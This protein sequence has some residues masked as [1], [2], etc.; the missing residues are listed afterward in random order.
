LGNGDPVYNQTSPVAVADLTGARL[1][2]TAV[3][4]AAGSGATCA[5]L[6]SG[7]SECWGD[8]EQGQLGNSSFADQSTPAGVSGLTGGTPASAVSLGHVVATQPALPGVPSAVAGQS[9][10]TTTIELSWSA[11]EN[12]GGAD[13]TDYALEYRVVGAPGELEWV[14]VSHQHGATTTTLIEGLTSGAT[15]AFRVAAITAAGQG[16]WSEESASVRTLRV[17]GTPGTP[18]IVSRTSTSITIRWSEASA[19][20]SAPVLYDVQYRAGSGS[21]SM[22]ERADSSARTATAT[23][24]RAGSSY[25]FRVRAVTQ[26]GWGAWSAVSAAAVAAGK[27]GLPGAVT[28]SPTR[29]PGQLLVTWTA[30]A[31]NGA[32]S[33]RYEVAWRGRGDWSAPV[34]AQGRTYLITGLTKGVYAVRVTAITVE[35]S[36][37]AIRTGINL[38]K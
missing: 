7:A 14:R 4:V 12:D 1:T 11:P 13:I 29:R 9:Y 28:A 15:Y 19:N 32:P 24:L 21:W 17:P 35:G 6:A 3:A 5:V 16:A 18:V 8:N 36:T 27:P 10:S 25:T 31:A 38:P 2:T 30:S 26:A 23:G 34:R 33:V 37:P 22:L 20:G